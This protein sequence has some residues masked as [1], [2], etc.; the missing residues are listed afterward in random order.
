MISKIFREFFSRS[1]Y[2]WDFYLQQDIFLLELSISRIVYSCNAFLGLLLK[3]SRLRSMRGNGTKL[4]KLLN[5]KMTVLHKSEYIDCASRT[6]VLYF[7][8]AVNR[9][10]IERLME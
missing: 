3:Q 6:K 9:R 4:F 10:A 2:G 1:T 7:Q 5:C 8:I